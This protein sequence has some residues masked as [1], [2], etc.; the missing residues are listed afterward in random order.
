MLASLQFVFDQ[1]FGLLVGHR[2][3]DPHD[4]RTEIPILAMSNATNTPTYPKPAFYGKAVTMKTEDYPLSKPT[5]HDTNL[6]N[7]Q[8]VIT[9]DPNGRHH[10]GQITYK[11]EENLHPQPH[12]PRHPAQL[13]PVPKVRSARAS[14]HCTSSSASNKPLS[15]NTDREHS[16]TS[17]HSPA[18][19]TKPLPA[20]PNEN[21]STA[22][23]RTDFVIRHP[24]SSR[25]RNEHTSNGTVGTVRSG[26]VESI[27]DDID[28]YITPKLGDPEHDFDISDIDDVMRTTSQ[29]PDEAHMDEDSLE[30]AEGVLEETKPTPQPTPPPPTLKKATANRV[31]S[32]GIC[33]ALYLA[34]KQRQALSHAKEPRLSSYLRS[35]TLPNVNEVIKLDEKPAQSHRRRSVAS[36]RSQSTEVFDKNNQLDTSK[37]DRDSGFDEQDFRCERLHSSYDDNSSMSSLKSARNSIGRSLSSDLNG[38]VYRENKAYELRL[39]ALDYSRVLNEQATQEPRSNFRR[40]YN[41]LATRTNDTAPSTHRYKKNNHL[42]LY[43][44]C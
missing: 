42:N 8:L 16:F 25:S 34:Q 18:R 3:L 6:S 28:G 44:K 21:Q 15:P 4:Q 5:S 41:Y 2:R 36:Q 24:P 12:C 39:K 26:F 20:W 33:T 27:I 17:T 7:A 11:S 35:S 40:N 29:Q 9:R 13:S 30:S 23:S 10:I 19:E 43:F 31:K 38:H 1:F 22:Y 14:E 37:L 32:G